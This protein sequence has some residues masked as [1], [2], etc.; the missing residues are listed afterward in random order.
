MLY[1]Q[2]DSFTFFM[3]TLMAKTVMEGIGYGHYTPS[4]IASELVLRSSSKKSQDK[5]DPPRLESESV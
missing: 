2:L 1:D 3:T 4:M 5:T